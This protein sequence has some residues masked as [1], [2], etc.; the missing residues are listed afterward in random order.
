MRLLLAVV[1]ALG[2]I[3]AAQAWDDLERMQTATELGDLLAS[4]T[5][6]GFAYNS[7][8]ISTYID[9]NVPADDMGFNPMLDMMM[10]G[11]TE[12]MKSM[13]DSQKVAHCRQTERVAKAH[14][15]LD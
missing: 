14:G 7:D 10:G 8:A 6:C 13:T 4:E 1:F 3:S 2:S 9:E 11:R 15:F 12:M 5:V